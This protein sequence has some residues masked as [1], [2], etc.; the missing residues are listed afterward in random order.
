MKCVDAVN[1]EVDCR[2][3]LCL[4]S[5]GDEEKGLEDGHGST[6]KLPLRHTER[7]GGPSV[8]LVVLEE[9]LQGSLEMEHRGH[10][11]VG[12]VPARGV[13]ILQLAELHT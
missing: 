11:G 5:F 1:D 3:L 6:D 13:G 9:G 7:Q 2:C 12:T 10:V 4:P 8:G